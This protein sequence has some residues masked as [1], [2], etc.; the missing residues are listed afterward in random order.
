MTLKREI[1]RIIAKI[2]CHECNLKNLVDTEN[3]QTFLLPLFD[4]RWTTLAVKGCPPL[5]LGRDGVH[6]G[7]ISFQ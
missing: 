5:Q 4:G 1:L 3:R 2:A 7:G 6:V